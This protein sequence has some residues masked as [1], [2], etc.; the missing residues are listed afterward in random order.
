MVFTA[1]LNEEIWCSY[2]VFLTVSER[3][4]ELA[5][6]G[7]DSVKN[8]GFLWA[9]SNPTFVSNWV[10]MIVLLSLSVGPFP[11]QHG[12]DNKICFRKTKVN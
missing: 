12:K 4:W 11:R 1:M 9:E 3:R 10:N 7:G 6:A 2:F 8:N 5:D